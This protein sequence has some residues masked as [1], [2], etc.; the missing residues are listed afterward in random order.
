MPTDLAITRPCKRFRISS[1]LR[2][3]EFNPEDR[4]G[5]WLSELE[6][7]LLSDTNREKKIIEAK[8]ELIK[9]C[10]AGLSLCVGDALH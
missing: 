9:L 3:R 10:R 7:Q 8:N 6:V 1:T 5:T 4:V 2:T